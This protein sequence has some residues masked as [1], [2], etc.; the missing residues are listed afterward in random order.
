MEPES[1]SALSFSLPFKPASFKGDDS[2][3][4]IPC[5]QNC[6]VYFC[7]LKCRD[8]AQRTYHS[9][10]CTATAPK[11]QQLYDLNPD[12]YFALG[13]KAF[14]MILSNAETLQQD[15]STKSNL[16]TSSA[17]TSTQPAMK[18]EMKRKLSKLCVSLASKPFLYFTNVPWWEAGVAPKDQ[19]VSQKEWEEKRRQSYTQ[20]HAL[21][22]AAL[23]TSWQEKFPTA[24]E[25]ELFARILGAFELNNL[26]LRALCPLFPYYS[27]LRSKGRIVEKKAQQTM[28]RQYWSCLE[29]E[30]NT[31]TIGTGLFV[32][33]CCMNHSCQPSAKIVKS[34]EDL[35]NKLLVVANWN[36]KKGDEICISYIDLE[37]Q[38]SY[39]DRQ[40]ACKEYLFN[41][42]C[43]ICQQQNLSQNKNPHST[44]KVQTQKPCAEILGGDPINVVVISR[45]TDGHWSDEVTGQAD[46]EEEKANKKKKKKK[47]KKGKK[48]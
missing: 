38:S 35:D 28:G 17:S 25:P 41:C 39:A 11:I 27:S 14:A 2:E 42:A 43:E 37:S 40:E 36:I 10:I 8:T 24:F 30:C 20:A 5:A 45:H 33:A 34:Q 48:R 32:L 1:V 3:R 26:T 29:S 9:I 4:I 13:A 46:R 15:L 44:P 19:S 31:M 12:S 23:P 22:V 7:S 6:G 47:K 16:G 21:L 18:D